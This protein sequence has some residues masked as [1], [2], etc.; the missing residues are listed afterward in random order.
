MILVM[1][2]Q[3]FLLQAPYSGTEFASIV[4]YPRG[5][6]LLPSSP[7]PEKRSNMT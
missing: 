5:G 4:R 7:A 3:N 2:R 6:S 1:K